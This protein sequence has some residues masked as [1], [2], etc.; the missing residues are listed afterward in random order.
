MHLKLESVPENH[1]MSGYQQATPMDASNSGE[2]SL[3]ASPLSACVMLPQDLLQLCPARIC[4]WRNGPSEADREALTP[5]QENFFITWSDVL[6][7][8]MQPG[9]LNMQSCCSS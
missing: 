7:L 5:L 1:A 3:C 8:D 2:L 9:S 6:S 4:H